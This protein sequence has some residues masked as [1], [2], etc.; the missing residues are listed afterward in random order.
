MY[1][2]EDGNEKVIDIVDNHNCYHL[3]VSE[4][5]VDSTTPLFD[6][7]IPN[8]DEVMIVNNP[9]VKIYPD[10]NGIVID[11][12]AKV[13]EKGFILTNKQKI[14]AIL[15]YEDKGK[16]VDKEIQFN[17]INNMLDEDNPTTF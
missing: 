9:V 5:I 4:D 16:I 13:L 11:K 3:E 10:E 15:S 8:D 17:I 7:I 12:N 2:D 6:I 1:E 14:S